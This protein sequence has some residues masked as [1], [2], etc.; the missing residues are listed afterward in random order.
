[1]HSKNTKQL[2]ADTGRK[3][4]WKAGNSGCLLGLPGARAVPVFKLLPA[5]L[6]I[7][8]LVGKSLW[9][10]TQTWSSPVLGFSFSC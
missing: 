7:S 3:G 2:K 4:G 1:M 9:D 6:Q 5:E 10:K 8:S